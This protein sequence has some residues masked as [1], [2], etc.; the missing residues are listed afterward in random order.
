M[1]RAEKEPWRRHCINLTFVYRLSGEQERDDGDAADEGGS[2]QRA[3]DCSPRRA[4]MQQQL[5]HWDVVGAGGQLER[6]LTAVV[7][8]VRAE[9][10][11][12]LRAQPRHAT[13]VYIEQ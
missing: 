2:S 9:T 12:H 4:E 11:S 5:N 10:R 3:V 6:R 8:A 1:P 7:D 13:R